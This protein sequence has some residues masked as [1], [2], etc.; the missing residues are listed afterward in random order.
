MSAL[1]QEERDHLSPEELARVDAIFSRP[2]ADLLAMLIVI[3]EVDKT[4]ETRRV[5]LWLI[6]ALEA[7]FDVAAAMDAWAAD[8]GS[9]ITY[10]EALVA[11]INQ[12]R[13]TTGD[14][15]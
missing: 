3:D 8:A 13:E 15:T 5:R 11:T 9:N 14:P 6:R 4:P 7:R 12:I 2:T 10:V 1:T